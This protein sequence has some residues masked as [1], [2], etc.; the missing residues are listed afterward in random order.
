MN[1]IEIK[2]LTK[3]FG[4]HKVLDNVSLTVPQKQIIGLVGINGSGKTML[5][6]CI[7]GFVIPEKGEIVVN[8]TTIGEKNNF[9][10][11]IGIIIEMPGFLPVYSGITNLSI[12]ASYSGKKSK[13]ELA[14]LMKKVGL[15]PEDKRPV[16]KY[17]MGMR[18]RL[19]IAQAIMDNPS[20]LVLD[21]PFNGLD[22]KGVE[23]IR[24][25]LINLRAEGKTMILTSHHSEDIRSLC[26]CVY[27]MDG[28]QIVSKY[29]ADE[30]DKKEEKE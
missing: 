8:G 11:D 4:K 1:S 9:A 25:L 28:G 6:R 7:C 5:M 18:Q 29:E 23:E 16:R 15:D 2:N 19:G 26:D 13:E 30:W 14:L 27:E 22:K 21:E 12:L 17:S 10:K 24:K 20:L 3:T